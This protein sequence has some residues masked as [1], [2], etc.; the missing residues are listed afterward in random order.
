MKA[1]AYAAIRLGLR[2]TEPLPTELHG[3]ARLTM[4][5]AGRFHLHVPVPLKLPP[6]PTSALLIDTAWSRLILVFARSRRARGRVRAR[7]HESHHTPVP[8]VRPAAEQDGDSQESA[9]VT[10]TARVRSPAVQ[11]QALHRRSA[12]PWTSSGVAGGLVMT[13]GKDSIQRLR[14][15]GSFSI[16]VSLSTHAHTHT[17]IHTHTESI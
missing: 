6:T 7:R 2:K 5:R 1:S 12:P 13:A 4:D 15:T 17:H 9:Q 3:D 8:R 16:A 11:D 14:G 10:P